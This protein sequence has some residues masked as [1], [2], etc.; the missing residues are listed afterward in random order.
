[1]NTINDRTCVRCEQIIS[2]E[3]S[4]YCDTCYSKNCEEK[5]GRCV[6]CKQINTGKNWCQNCNSKRFQ[7]NFDKWTSGN[8]NIDKLIQNS[9]LTAKSYYHILEWIPYNT[10]GKSKYI[11]EGGFGKVYK[12]TWRSGNILH[13]DRDKQQWK[14]GYRNKSN[15]F[16]ALKTLNKSQNITLEFINEVKYLYDLLKL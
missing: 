10:F 5:H 7:Q 2:Y 13:W 16:V 4:K 15:A 1:M 8:D 3:K 6:E 14:R 12:A 11:A 9:Q